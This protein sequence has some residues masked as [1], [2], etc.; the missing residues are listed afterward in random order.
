MSGPAGSNAD[1]LNKPSVQEDFDKLSATFAGAMDDPHPL[2]RELRQTK[3]VMEGDILATLGVWSQAGVARPGR[4]IYSLFKYDDVM[5]VMR[6]QRTYTSG[7]VLEQ[8]GTFLGRMMT[9][10]DGEEHRQLRALLAP[11]FSPRVIEAMRT[12]MVEPVARR[13]FV[14]V[15]KPKKRSDLLQDV[16]VPYPVRAIYDVMGFPN[17]PDEIEQ[18]AAWAL[19]ILAGPDVDP[20]KAAEAQMAAFKAAQ[21][22]YDHCIKLVR[23]RRAEGYAGDDLIGQLLRA[24][25]ESR[26]LND[27]EITQILRQFLPAAAETTTRSFANMLVYLLREPELMEAVRRDRKLIARAMHETMRVDPAP[28]YLARQCARDVEIRGV[29]IPKGAALSLALGSA[30]RDEDYFPEPDKFDLTRQER[31]NFGFGIGAHLCLGMPVARIEMEVM[32]N[33]LLDELPNLRLDPDAAPP[34]IRGIQL[35]GA[36]CVPVIWD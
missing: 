2:Y 25:F 1:P 28:Q 24:S 3:P 22:L 18:F 30:S 6:D 23:K 20:E 10:L 19:R 13:E 26:T 27:D 21:D 34:V 4:P 36:D 16:L 11:C 9:G 12:T 29:K 35:R 15:I 33:A 17:D 8:L 7:L 5:G 31:P 14:D 32:T